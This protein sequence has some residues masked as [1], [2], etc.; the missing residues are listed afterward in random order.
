MPFLLPAFALTY[1][2]I[3][4]LG[5]SLAII[6]DE[7]VSVLIEALPQLT[8]SFQLPQQLTRKI[9]AILKVSQ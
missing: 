6:D 3:V 7:G 1:Q 8:P 2:T 9:P 5:S 4:I